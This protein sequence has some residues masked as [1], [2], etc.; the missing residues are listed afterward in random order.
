M[1]ERDNVPVLSNIFSMS[2]RM[3]PDSYHLVDLKDLS[4]LSKMRCNSR[5]F[6]GVHRGL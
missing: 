6:R 2:D 5:P 4:Q 1:P 3:V